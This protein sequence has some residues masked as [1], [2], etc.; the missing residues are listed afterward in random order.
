MLKTLDQADRVRLR[1]SAQIEQKRK[2]EMGQFLTP[3]ATARFM[4]SLIPDVGGQ[5]R[6]LDP[7]AG[8]GA[9]SCAVLDRWAEGGLHFDHATIEAHEIDQHLLVHLREHLEAYGNRLPVRP[10]IVHGDFVENA[11][12]RSIAR[13]AVFTHV[14]M[15]P[16]YKKINSGSQCRSDLRRAGLETVNLYS[17][18]VGLALDLL[19]TGGILVAIIPRSWC[20]GPYYRPFR[21]WVLS[22]AA[23]RRLHLFERRNSAFKDDAVLQENVIVVLERGGHQGPVSVSTSTDDTFSDLE[24]TEHAF[25]K[26]VQPGDPERFVHIPKSGEADPLDLPD[27]THTLESLGLKVSTG[28][29]VDFRL[30]DNMRATP[31]ECTAPLLYPGHLIGYGVQWPINGFKK[32]NAIVDDATSHKWL[33]PNGWYTVVRR[34]SSKE[35]RRRV[36]A[37]VIDPTT[38]GNAK[39]LGLENHLNFI[40]EKKKPL[41]ADLARGLAVFL[42][43]TTVDESFRSFNGHTQVN[44]TDIKNMRFPNREVLTALGKWLSRCNDVPDQAALDAAFMETIR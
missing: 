21:D 27:L 14:V 30:R 37:G 44:A 22:R 19:V 4:A 6:L 3:A 16:P 42:N 7:G 1:V 13:R 18:F 29:V 36:V 39:W 10:E 40:H 5:C 38:F 17:G 26:I 15:N 20:N 33:I 23:I 24:L 2:S 41:S 11:V 28:P 35:E 31:D 9:L 12:S 8:V 34:F 43:T 25:D 32:P